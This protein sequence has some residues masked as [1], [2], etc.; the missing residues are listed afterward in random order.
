MG[1]ETSE[2]LVELAGVVEL[3]GFAPFAGSVTLAGL[4]VLARF[5]T[6]SF[7]SLFNRTGAVGKVASACMEVSLSDT[8][9]SETGNTGGVVETLFESLEAVFS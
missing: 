1:V 7:A 2:D 6:N 5:D 4:A 8:A 9:V 3:A